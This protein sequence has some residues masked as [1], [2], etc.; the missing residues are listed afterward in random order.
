MTP[1]LGHIHVPDRI[2]KLKYKEKEATQLS[3]KYG[4]F[5]KWLLDRG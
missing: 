5:K 4:Q 2:D 1:I 3:I